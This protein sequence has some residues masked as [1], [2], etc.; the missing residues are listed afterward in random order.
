MEKNEFELREKTDG[1]FQ[2]F[3]SLRIPIQWRKPKTS[4]LGD[5]VQVKNC[6]SGH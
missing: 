4:V 1:N 3:R 5:I 2:Q 6:R